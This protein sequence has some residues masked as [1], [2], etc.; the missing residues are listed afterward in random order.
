MSVA[1]NPKI[2]VFRRS[3]NSV[4]QAF[5]FNHHVQHQGSRAAVLG[6]RRTSNPRVS[7]PSAR[8]FSVS[9]TQ[10]DKKNAA[11]RSGPFDPFFGLRGASRKIRVIA[12][13]RVRR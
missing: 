6:F 11:A 2:P 5:L 1:I 3:L 12:H 7:W 10:P 13:N 4:M 9:E 8:K